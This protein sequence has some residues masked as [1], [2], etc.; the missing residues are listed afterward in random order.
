MSEISNEHRVQS[1]AIGTRH[2]KNL[3]W[4]V[5]ARFF[6]FP[7]FRLRALTLVQFVF[8]SVEFMIN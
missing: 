6:Q 1:L 3:G 5:Y 8:F 4:A 2:A 7:V